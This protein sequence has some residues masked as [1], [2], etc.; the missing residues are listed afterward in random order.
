MGHVT[1]LVLLVLALG[2]CA[3]TV[4]TI[5]AGHTLGETGESVAIGRVEI[6]RPDGRPL[7]PA[8]DVFV[9]RMALTV[10]NETNGRSYVISCDARG[11][12]SDF[13]VSLPS[14]RY[15]ITQWNSAGLNSGIE[16]W[17]EVGPRQVVYVGTLRFTGGGN[18]VSWRSGA[19][20]VVD[21]SE[22]TLRSFRERFP[23]LQEAA[24][25]S[26]MRMGPER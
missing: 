20:T 3:T 9:G 12:L 11:F 16:A 5:P 25:K 13:Y 2:G 24:A 8:P 4:A 10:E 26:L 18:I 14:G 19:W 23:Q 17:F 6:V 1:T 15:R 22:S 7:T 21:A